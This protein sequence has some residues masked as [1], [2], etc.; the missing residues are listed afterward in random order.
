MTFHVSFSNGVRLRLIAISGML[1]S[2]LNY[3]AR[4]KINKIIPTSDNTFGLRHGSLIR[5]KTYLEIP[6]EQLTRTENKTH[7]HTH[8]VRTAGLKTGVASANNFTWQ[9]LKI[10]HML[11]L[12]MTSALSFLRTSISGTEKDEKGKNEISQNRRYEIPEVL[13]RHHNIHHSCF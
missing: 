9:A 1:F 13:Q 8:I 4:H 12:N 10:L 3:R 2:V 7:T 5:T 11:S 6:D